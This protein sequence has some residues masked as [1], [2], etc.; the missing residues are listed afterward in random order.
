MSKLDLQQ[1]FKSDLK[2]HSTPDLTE[3]RYFGGP[4]PIFIWDDLCDPTLMKEVLGVD[5]NYYDNVE[6]RYYLAVTKGKFSPMYN[7]TETSNN[8][9]HYCL[10][11]DEDLDFLTLPE[12]TVD[13]SKRMSGKIYYVSIEALQSLDLY[14]ENES[15]FNRTMIEVNPTKNATTTMKCFTW[16][17][18]LDQISEETLDQG[19]EYHLRKDL[20]FCHFP[21]NNDGFYSYNGKNNVH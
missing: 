8:Y 17:N 21:T 14:Y 13:E 6:P 19:F 18:D 16:M 4:L 10:E 9:G 20:D 5:L 7:I 12:Y 2:F 1:Q 11:D 3:L 15:L